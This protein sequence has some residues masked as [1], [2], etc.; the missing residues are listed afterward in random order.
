VKPHLSCREAARLVLAA[1][2]RRLNLSER[3]RLRLHMAIC[4]GCPNFQQQVDFM[5]SAMGQWRRYADSGD[6]RTA[7]PGR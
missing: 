4:K 7:P 6:D 5:R 2:D 3:L 1:E